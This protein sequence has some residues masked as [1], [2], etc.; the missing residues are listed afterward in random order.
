MYG[1]Q[2]SERLL[3]LAEP[4]QLFQFLH[5]TQQVQVLNK[6]HNAVM[7]ANSINKATYLQEKSRVYFVTLH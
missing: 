1:Q 6:A 3:E 5:Y 7:N 2:H 4:S